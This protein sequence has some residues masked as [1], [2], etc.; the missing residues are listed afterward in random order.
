MTV[1]SPEVACNGRR[2]QRKLAIKK[3]DRPSKHEFV[4]NQAKQLQSEMNCAFTY[5]IKQ[6]RGVTMKKLVILLLV[7]LVAVSLCVSC[8]SSS[9]KAEAELYEALVGSWYNGNQ[10]ITFQKD[11]QEVV[12]A[13]LLQEGEEDS[14]GYQ[15]WDYCAVS[16]TEDTISVTLDVT[17]KTYSFTYTLE[18]NTMT[19]AVASGSEVYSEINAGT[20]TRK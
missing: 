4:V 7:A 5:G 19:L 6:K 1:T 11:K 10:R 20:W 8:D 13:E 12:T 9:K 2:G 3:D 15:E 17:K 18:A 16:V 14:G